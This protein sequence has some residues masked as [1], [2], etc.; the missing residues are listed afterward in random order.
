M[1]WMSTIHRSPSAWFPII[2]AWG[3]SIVITLPLVRERLEPAA[4]AA[5]A[6]AEMAAVV[7]RED[8]DVPCC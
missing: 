2:V 6:E 8:D 7:V 1:S 3:H 4:P 5:T